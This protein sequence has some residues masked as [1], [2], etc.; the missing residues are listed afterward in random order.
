MR[1]N[2]LALA[3]IV[4]KVTRV[5]LLFGLADECYR[6]FNKLEPSV[7]VIRG[8][9]YPLPENFAGGRKSE[10]LTRLNQFGNNLFWQFH[11][12]VAGGPL[13]R[14]D[15][16]TACYSTQAMVAHHRAFLNSSAV[17]DV[18]GDIPEIAV[19][20]VSFHESSG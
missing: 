4:P 11:Y 18:V 1:G 10:A 2:E 15:K 17:D 6:F 14:G 5:S 12:Q 20:M 16:P 13:D 8:D 7:G 3:Q 19:F 9:S